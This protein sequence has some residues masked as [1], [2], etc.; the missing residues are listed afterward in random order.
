[1]KIA[2]FAHNYL[3][4]PGGLEVM[5]F[6][7]ARR[8]AERHEVV[9]VSS[10]YEQATG[11]THEDGMQVHRLPTS[12]F[13]EGRGVPYPVPIGPGVSAA[14]QAVAGADVVH[15][16]G[17]L[18]AQT[19]MAR[20]TARR[21]GAP[22]VL[23]EHV[24]FVQYA[25]PALNAIQRS[26]WAAIGDGTLARCAEVVTY[27]ARVHGWLEERARRPVRFVGNGV[28][29]ER[30]RRR[31][32]EER[33]ALRRSFA[34]PEDEVVALFVG[35]D[36]GKK[37]LDV[38]LAAPRDG[39]VLATCGARRNLRG[40]RLCDLGIV[41]YDR[42]AELFGCVDFMVHPA[43]GE[44]FPLAVQEAI[45]AGVPVVLLWDEGYAHSLPR[46]VVTACDDVSAVAPA[47]LALAKDAARRNAL[48]ARGQEWAR[49]HWSWATT[50]AAYEE[51]YHAGIAAT[52]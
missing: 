16:H 11:V 5:V 37:N 3:P 32:G 31:E 42:M 19:L 10:A 1:M 24:G 6:N 2:M 9:L 15:A 47:M 45:A 43:S 52:R 46:D 33:R 29:L 30:F 23:T 50:V 22:L 18:Y 7:L 49:E 8:L 51:I 20:R 26:A 40:D 27:N 41:P 36:A 4:H 21:S 35:R 14:M 13:T 34:L 38:V 44:G 48:S 17:A 12:H 39:F 28:D 25:Q